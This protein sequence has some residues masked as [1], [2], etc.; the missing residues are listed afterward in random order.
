MRPIYHRLADRV[1]AHV[2]L[3]MLAYY[4]EW[5]LRRR[6]APLLFDDEDPAAGKALR[7][8]VV[9]PARRSPK[10]EDKAAT[11]TTD[12]G[13]PVFSFQ[14]LLHDLATLCKNT[15]IAQLP[16]AVAFEQYTLP[17]EVQQRAFDLL[18]VKVKL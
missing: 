11:R 4:V 6:L 9:A 8:S 14:G 3:C 10:A 17:T 1:R 15:V 5:H 7:R 16:D 12:D 13:L 2:F 18:G